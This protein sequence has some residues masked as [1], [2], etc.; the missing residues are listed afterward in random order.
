MSALLLYSFSP[1]TFIRSFQTSGSCAEIMS[2][3]D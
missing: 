3:A 1:L 2:F